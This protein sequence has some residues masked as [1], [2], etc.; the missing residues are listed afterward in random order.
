MGATLAP[1]RGRPALVAARRPVQY[2]L[3]HGS[4]A[5]RALHERF[6]AIDLHADSLMWSRWVGYDLHARHEP[7]LPFAAI[8]AE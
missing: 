3:M 6:P 5:A 2:S 1:N 7:P 4:P 8:G